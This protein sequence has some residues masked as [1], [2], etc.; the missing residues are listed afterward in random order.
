MCDI[1]LTLILYSQNSLQRRFPLLK[2]YAQIKQNMDLQEQL[3][4]QMK[5]NQEQMRGMND[6]SNI[7]G[8]GRQSD[9]SGGISAF[10]GGASMDGTQDHGVPTDK[11][12]VGDSTRE[13][14]KSQDKPNEDLQ[15]MYDRIIGANNGV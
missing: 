1:D 7:H 14:A 8:S 6:H 15:Q 5:R 4:M 12:S 3:H 10:R 9:P 2:E 13:I 11:F